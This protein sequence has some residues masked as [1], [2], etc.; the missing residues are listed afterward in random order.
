MRPQEPW[1]PTPAEIQDAFVGVV[2]HHCE[3]LGVPVRREGRLLTFGNDEMTVE[4]RLV[5]CPPEGLTFEYSIGLPE[6][7]TRRIVQPVTFM[8]TDRSEALMH[9]HQLVADG[10]LAPLLASLGYRW[11]EIDVLRTTV[12]FTAPDGSALAW[13][14][15][16][17]PT[18][19]YADSEQSAHAASNRLERGHP[20]FDVVRRH[21]A[22]VTT[23]PGLHW[24][25]AM[26]ARFPGDEILGDVWYDDEQSADAYAD[27]LK[28]EVPG[29][30]FLMFRQFGVLRPAKGQL[31][32]DG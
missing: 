25:K 15:F 23:Q 2:A 8:H 16:A 11:P 28:I 14:L 22:A 30:G 29:A 9:C 3:H 24:W 27:L 6:L 7:G 13:E 17:G 10:V 31:P 1:D 26:Y 19:V 4:L 5:D 20:V 18:L 12:P 32:A 21:M